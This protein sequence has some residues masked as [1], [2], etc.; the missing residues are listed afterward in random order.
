MKAALVLVVLCCALAAA[1]A[2]PSLKLLAKVA[3]LK[4][5]ETIKYK[6]LPHLGFAK[7]NAVRYEPLRES[8]AAA[9]AP[10]PAEVVAP[11]PAELPAPAPAGPYPAA[12]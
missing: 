4:K 7:Y 5:A 9:P 2:A 10:Y 3:G 1:S 6:L 11:Y 8:P 12:L